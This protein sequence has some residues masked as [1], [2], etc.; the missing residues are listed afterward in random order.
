[1]D[2]LTE[3]LEGGYWNDDRGEFCIPTASGRVCAK[4]VVELA[5]R[6]E[7]LEKELSAQALGTKENGD[8]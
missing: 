1:M 3:F 6:I 4:S 8:G 2:D 5:D 7:K